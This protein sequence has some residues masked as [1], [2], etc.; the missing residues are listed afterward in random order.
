MLY[1]ARD[2]LGRRSLLQVSSSDGSTLLSS[3]SCAGSTVAWAEVDA[4][5]VF[6]LDLKLGKVN[7]SM[8]YYNF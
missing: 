6:S 8:G 4:S 2:P 1:W 7:E 3:V 5:C